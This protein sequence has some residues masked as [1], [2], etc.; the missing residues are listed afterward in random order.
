LEAARRSTNQRTLGGPS[1]GYEYW[2]TISRADHTGVNILSARAWKLAIFRRRVI[3]AMKAVG[4]R[5]AAK[6]FRSW[7]D[8]DYLFRK[9]TAADFE[10]GVTPAKSAAN[11]AEVFKE[12]TS[13]PLNRLAL[14]LWLQDNPQALTAV[15]L[16]PPATPKSKQR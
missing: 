7:I 3:G 10:A 11:F 9:S 2:Y 8:L 16:K 12:A 1:D 15:G 14:R 5:E 6:E 4:A 13:P